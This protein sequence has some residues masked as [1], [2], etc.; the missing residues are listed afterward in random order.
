MLKQE[1]TAMAA[2][3]SKDQD[4]SLVSKGQFTS[5]DDLHQ[6]KSIKLYECPHNHNSAEQMLANGQQGDN[7]DSG[8]VPTDAF[9]LSEQN[10]DSQREEP[11]TVFKEQKPQM[12]D[13]ST[14]ELSNT[15]IAPE[16]LSLSTLYNR[17]LNIIQTK[18]EI[19]GQVLSGDIAIE[20]NSSSVN[21]RSNSDKNARNERGKLKIFLGAAPGVGK[22]FAMLTEANEKRKQGMDIVITKISD[23]CPLIYGD[24]V[25]LERVLA[26]VNEK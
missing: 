3:D 25:L 6:S 19:I 12:Y 1:G 7:I 17:D 21:S 22:T 5:I 16:T 23:T 14:V 9:Y 15:A 20:L 10:A 18:P 24:P 11:T 2:H 8:I 13:L 4:V 26:I